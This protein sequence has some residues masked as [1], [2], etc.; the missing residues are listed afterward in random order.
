MSYFRHSFFFCAKASHQDTHLLIHIAVQ[1]GHGFASLACAVRSKLR[2][3]DSCCNFL[4]SCPVNSF[5]EIC[6]IG[7]I[8]KF[9][10]IAAWTSGKSPE[11]GDNLFTGAFFIGTEGCGAG[12]CC[13]SF[14]CSPEDS[15]VIVIRWANIRKW[16]FCCCWIRA[17][18]SSP[19]E[20]NDLFSFTSILGCKFVTGYARGNLRCTEVRPE[21]RFI[22]MLAAF[23]F[24]HQVYDLVRELATGPRRSIRA[25]VLS[26]YGQRLLGVRK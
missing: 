8:Q 9:V 13:D 3:A 19:E 11:E 21:N 2:G 1:E 18:G 24:L 6:I 12:S 14:F 26:E 15:I 25:S 22:V 16:I 7:D 20:G 10:L 5:C 4:C 23:C 17:S